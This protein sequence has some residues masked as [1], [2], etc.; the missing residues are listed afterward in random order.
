MRRRLSLDGRSKEG[1]KQQRPAQSEA[2]A[3]ILAAVG[4]GR[5][6]RWMRALQRLMLMLMLMLMM[7]VKLE[8]DRSA[9]LQMAD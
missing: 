8:T 1:T 5:G 7:L 3:L 2:R 4:G 6:D 9:R